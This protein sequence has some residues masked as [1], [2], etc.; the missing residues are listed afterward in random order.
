MSD[1]IKKRI[2]NQK[3][4]IIKNIRTELDST[5][6]FNKVPGDV[7]IIPISVLYISIGN[8]LECLTRI[9]IFDLNELIVY[10]YNKIKSKFELVKTI[11]INGD[12]KSATDFIRNYITSEHPDAIA[13]AK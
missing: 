11:E 3:S 8:N 5:F 13:A 9:F 12:I 10:Y 2:P 4:D 7:N 1:I 6:V